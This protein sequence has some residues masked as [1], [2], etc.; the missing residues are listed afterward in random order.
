MGFIIKNTAGLVNTR[1]TDTGRQKLSEG[2]FQIK[3]FQIGDSEVS[4]NSLPDTYNLANN[5]I[6]EPAFNSQNSAGIPESNK[7]N[8]KY[9]FYVNGSTGNTYGI[10]FM[11]SAAEQVFNSAPL[12]GFFSGNSS[13]WSALTNDNYVITS[14]YVVDV[15][16]LNGTNE[17]TLIF[18]GCNSQNYN[19]P[20]VGDII[21]MYL[22]GNAISNCMCT[23]L[24]TPTP[25]PT[26]SSSPVTGVTPTPTPSYN[27]CNNPTPTPTPSSTKSC[28]PVTPSSKPCP[29]EPDPTCLM[30]ISS[31]N[32]ILTYKIVS[33]CNGVY[34]LD[35]TTP[36]FSSWSGSC[37]ARVLVYPSTMTSLYDSKTPE[38]HWNTDVIN[39]ESVCDVDAFDIKIWNMNIPWTESP[40]GLFSNT[41]KD[42]SNFGSINY[43]GTKEYFGY[44]SSSGQTF[45]NG[46]TLIS[47]TTDTFIYNSFDEPIYI[48]PEDQKAISIIHYTNHAIDNFYGEKFAFQPYDTS[49]PLDTTGEARNFKL[50]LPWLMWHKASTCCSGQTF[51]VDPAGF[52]NYDLFSINY[53][54]STK[55]PDMNNPGLRYYHLWDTNPNTDGIPNRIGKVFP[56]LKMVVIDDEEIIAAMS[57]KSNRNWTLPAPKLSYIAPN[58]CGLGTDVANGILTGNSQTMFVTYRITDDTY[59]TN[60]L[61]CN[62]YMSLIGPNTTC[63]SLTSQ[64]VAIRF[65]NEFNC[66]SQP[67]TPLN[68]G[69]YG[70]NFEIICQLVDSGE[71]PNPSNWKIIN[72]TDSLSGTTINGFLTQS[73]ITGTTF[74]ITEDDYNSA[75]YYDLSNYIDLVGINSTGTTLNF[76]DEYFFY[77]SLVTD[78]EATIYEMKYKVNLPQNEFQKPSNPTWVDGN[79]TYI[80][81]IGLFDGNKDLLAIS[82]LQSPVL[83]QG[84][85]QFL[86]KIDI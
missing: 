1:I 22:D 85:Q 72:I 66:L 47:G 46:N 71:R 35:R 52:D 82:K 76:G 33:V 60:A 40:A 51:Y 30:A 64:N 14:N 48:E 20:S 74:V 15:A 79:K 77:G 49:N 24:P 17:I 31:C 32:L 75:S 26:P 37:A 67:T 54:Q 65:G 73:G 59:S 23:N 50:H 28:P 62:Y 57:Y 63:N 4:Y 42:Y 34:T 78:I 55:N 18:S 56:D 80:T 41:Y 70:T 9:P 44:N 5:I 38:P 69:Y 83:R 13:S 12:R 19:T 58:V 3:Y 86:V 68:Q 45:V 11:A 21:V 16:S 39:F 61:H 53:M 7:Q 81:E 6:L 29:A 84:I 2:N 8:I 36:D 43:I 10:P 25:T 27:P